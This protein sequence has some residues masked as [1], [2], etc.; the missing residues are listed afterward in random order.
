MRKG[1]LTRVML[2]LAVA[3]LGQMLVVQQAGIDL[4]VA[5]GIS[6]SVV[7]VTHFPNGDDGK[8]VPIETVLL[9]SR[10]SFADAID[11]G[12]KNFVDAGDFDSLLDINRARTDPVR[13]IT[14]DISC[15]SA[16]TASYLPAAAVWLNW[17]GIALESE[18]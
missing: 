13:P 3:G 7:V 1:M 9:T 8:L 16:P 4:S 6:L 18:M 5:G 14:S 17:N 12:R 11:E 10:T 15:S 2:V